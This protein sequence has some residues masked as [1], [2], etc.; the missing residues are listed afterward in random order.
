M[1]QFSKHLWLILGT[2]NLS[3]ALK[4]QAASIR[5]KI[6]FDK[7]TDASQK[8]V[9]KLFLMLFFFPSDLCVDLQV[10]S[11]TLEEMKLLNLYQNAPLLKYKFFFPICN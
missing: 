2:K 9:R 4:Q 1:M 7:T 5:Q 6:S 8:S 10:S 11:Y 3:S